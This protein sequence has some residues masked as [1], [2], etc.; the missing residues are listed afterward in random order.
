MSSLLLRTITKRNNPS[1]DYAGYQFNFIVYLQPCH[2]CF[3][4]KI[5]SSHSSSLSFNHVHPLLP[6]LFKKK[7]RRPSTPIQEVQKVLAFSVTLFFTLYHA[8]SVLLIKQMSVI[9][10]S[11]FNFNHH[12]IPVL[13]TL[14]CLCKECKSRSAGL[15]ANLSGTA[16]FVIKYVNLYKHPGSSILIEVGV[17]S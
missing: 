9:Q 16:L 4:N 14:A 7:K 3:T 8:I 15:E 17:A 6:L 13:L 11:F 12:V 1:P 5:I 10:Q 2:S